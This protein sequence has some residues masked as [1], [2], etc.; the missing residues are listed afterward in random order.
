MLFTDIKRNLLGVIGGVGPLATAYFMERVITFTDAS[1]DQE[2]IDMI[3]LNHCSIPDRTAYI[4][5]H[6]MPNPLPELA[7]DVKRLEQMGVKFI[8]TPCNTA[9]YFYN[10]LV[11]ISNTPILNMIEE[12]ACVL[13]R[14]DSK[15]IGIMATKGTIK[16]EL[17][18]QALSRKG[19][20][21]I[22]PDE[23]N[24]SII[25]S[26][27]FDSVKANKAVDM[28]KF[29]RVV[30]HLK[31]QGCDRIILGCTELSVVKRDYKLDKF[32][33]DSLD[34]L[35]V[36]VIRECDAPMVDNYIIND[37]FVE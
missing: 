32:Y 23:E 28:N 36:A 1:V 33:L 22:I 7:D 3:V 11:R 34:A 4:L 27:I 13:K 29:Y 9:H 6:D 20:N 10:D 19:L 37:D 24:Q 35:V 21:S 15:N 16:T 31:L 25:T 5:D 8:A 14:Q 2:H 26:I 12:T 17:F 30:D 18:Q